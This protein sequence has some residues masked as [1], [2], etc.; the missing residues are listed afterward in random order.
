MYRLITESVLGLRLEVDHLHMAPAFPAEWESFEIHYRY[1]ETF[2][3]IHVRRRGAGRK[4]IRLVIDG[5]ER[6]TFSIPLSDDRREH[7]V[8]V[9]VGESVVD[10][11]AAGVKPD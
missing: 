8:E 2:H 9:D 4:I 7:Q 6:P 3:H 5:V 11:G 10:A 1:R